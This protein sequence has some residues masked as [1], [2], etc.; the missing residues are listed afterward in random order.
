VTLKIEIVE[1]RRGLQGEARSLRKEEWFDTSYQAVETAIGH[2]RMPGV[3]N[4][5]YP[6]RHPIYDAQGNNVGFLADGAGTLGYTYYCVYVDRAYRFYL[7]H[8]PFGE[9]WGK[10]FTSSYISTVS[11]T[12][13]F[14]F[15]PGRKF[16]RTGSLELPYDW[17]GNELAFKLM[18]DQQHLLFVSQQGFCFVD[19][20]S[21]R[22]ISK[23]DFDGLS[24]SITGFA[25]SPKVNLLAMCFCASDGSDPLDGRPRYRSLLRIYHL[26]TG[27]L[28]GEK[29]IGGDQHAGWNV[30]FGLDGRQLAARSATSELVFD[31]QAS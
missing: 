24:H 16:A 12:G 18:N 8:V 23:T 5:R 13:G 28:V 3:S 11:V 30:V 6:S 9:V 2:L 15:R 4:G 22:A 26:D 10:R 25:L 29:R 17:V 31:L 21:C 27:A 14:L 20:G 19:T 1:S 7:S